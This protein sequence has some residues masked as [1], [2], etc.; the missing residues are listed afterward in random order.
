MSLANQVSA[1]AERI[2]QELQQRDRRRHCSCCAWQKLQT[3]YWHNAVMGAWF[4]HPPA[5]MAALPFIAGSAWMAFWF[6]EEK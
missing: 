1:L 3:T 5:L 4:C 2:G 6:P